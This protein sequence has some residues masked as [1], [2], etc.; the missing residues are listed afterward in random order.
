MIRRCKESF[1]TIYKFHQKWLILDIKLRA[2]RKPLYKALGLWFSTHWYTTIFSTLDILWRKFSR[3]LEER[4]MHPR[5]IHPTICCLG[6]SLQWKDQKEGDWFLLD[7]SAK[8]LD[9][10]KKSPL[11]KEFMRP[12]KSKNNSK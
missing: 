12:L 3:A 2:C 5:K 11:L 7:L 4:Q 10:M 1:T 6:D 9:E 8:A